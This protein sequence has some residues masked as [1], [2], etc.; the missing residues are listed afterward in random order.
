MKIR[1]VVK[2]MKE[3]VVED[4]ICHVLET[5]FIHICNYSKTNLPSLDF[6]FLRR[7]MNFFLSLFMLEC[8][9]YSMPGL[10]T[11]LAHIRCHVDP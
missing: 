11:M 6:Y 2:W 10:S 4:L 7:I 9:D 8:D 5:F 3:F 1:F